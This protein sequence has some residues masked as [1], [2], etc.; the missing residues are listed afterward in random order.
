MISSHLSGWVNDESLFLG[1]HARSDVRHAFK[2]LESDLIKLY[3]DVLKL[4]VELVQLSP[5]KG[6]GMV[7]QR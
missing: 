3:T 6:I 7:L 1:T 4:T 5:N 2:P